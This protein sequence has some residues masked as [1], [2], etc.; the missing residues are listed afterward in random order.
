MTDPGRLEHRV[1][2]L[3]ALVSFQERTIAALDDVLRTFTARVEQ[4]ERELE[5]ARQSD[6]EPEV[7]PQN[8][9]PPHY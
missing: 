3:E 5:R 6:Q 8:D 4:L 7:G 2:E 9:P 1:E